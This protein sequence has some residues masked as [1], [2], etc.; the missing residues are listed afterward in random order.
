MRHTGVIITQEKKLR[1]KGVL[2]NPL[3][4]TKHIVDGTS[5]TILLGEKYVPANEYLGGAYGDNFAWTRGAEWE[6]IRYSDIAP[7]NDD[8]VS[9]A[10][11]APTGE[12]ACDCWNFGAAH[13]GVFNAAFCDGSTRSIGYDVDLVVFK[14]M[15]NRA[16]GETYEYQ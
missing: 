7:L 5:K 9:E 2:R 13:P 8:P 3:I 12:L 16:D 6:G 14:M 10:N 11:R 1:D 4:S 15:T